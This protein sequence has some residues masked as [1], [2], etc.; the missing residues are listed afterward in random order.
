MS[1]PHRAELGRQEDAA[2]SHAAGYRDL[3]YHEQETL[4]SISIPAAKP[5]ASPGL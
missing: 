3:M 5:Q 4:F 1:S 2:A